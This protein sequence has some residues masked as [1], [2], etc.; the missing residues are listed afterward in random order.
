[1]SGLDIDMIE[2]TTKVSPGDTT[3]SISASTTGLTGDV[4]LLG[5]Y[6]ASI[7]TTKP[8]FTETNKTYTNLTRADGKI[9]PGD[10][11]EI[12]ITTKNSGGDVATGVI[13][14]DVLPSGMSYVAGSLQIAAGANAGAK[15]DQKAD[16][17]A[18]YD[19]LTRT[20]AFRLGTGATATA[21]GT[22]AINDTATVKFR[23]KIAAGAAGTIYNQ[24]SVTAGGQKAKAKGLA[25]DTWYSGDGTRPNVPTKFVVWCASNNDC[26]TSAPVCDTTLPVASCVCTTNA[27]CSGGL[28]CDTMGSKTCVECIPA[29]NT[30]NCTADGIGRL[31]LD[32]YQCGCI[33]NTDCN[34]RTCDGVTLR[35]PLQSSDVAVTVTRPQ[36]GTTISGGS[37]VQYQVTI[38]NKG[39]AAVNGVDLASVLPMGTSATWTCTG[40]GGATCPMASGSGAITGK[41]NLPA[42]GTLIYTVSVPIPTTYMGS[43][44][45]FR[46][47]ATVP[48]GYIDPNPGD[49]VGTDSAPFGNPFDLLLNVVTRP[50]AADGSI[51]YVMQ[52]TNK[53]PGAAPGASLS[54]A[55]PDGVTV[56]NVVAPSGWTCQTGSTQVVCTTLATIT[57]G[58]APEITITVAPPAGTTSFPVSATVVGTDGL[59]TLPDANP[60]DNTFMGTTMLGGQGPDLYLNVATAPIGSDG[61][62]TYTL[63]VGN[64]GPGDAPGAVVTYQIPTGATVSAVNPGEGWT[65]Q[66]QGSQLVCTTTTPITASGTAPPIQVTVVPPSGASGIPVGVQVVGQSASGPLTDPNPANNTYS[67]TTVLSKNGADLGLEVIPGKVGPGTAEYLLVVTNYGPASAQGA[68]VSYTIPLGATVSN[69][70]AG[71]GWTCSQTTDGRVL[72]TTTSVLPTGAVPPIKISVTTAPETTSIPLNAQVQSETAD[73][74][75][76]NNSVAGTTALMPGPNLVI[77]VTASPITPDNTITYTV[78]T[79]NLGPGTA[80]TATV[81]TTLPPGI[82]VLSVDGGSGWQCG[83]VSGQVICNATMPIPPGNAPDIKITVAVP[84]GTEQ[85]VVGANVIAKD[86][87]GQALGDEAPADNRVSVLTPVDK[88]QILGGG[89]G[90]NCDVAGP[91]QSSGLTLLSVAGLALALLYR[92]RRR[93]TVA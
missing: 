81:T 43:T 20:V 42:N 31:C 13:L 62:V 69:I 88:L 78:A 33:T 8:I 86:E 80:P 9:Y 79:Q 71:E 38:T 29:V 92:A 23:V 73:P 72:C 49:N 36:G 28:V 40:N 17:Q 11:L 30:T 84:P 12:S 1:M 83:V 93:R 18:D 51:S 16:D 5:V 89:F 53:G 55:I 47:S 39:P 44:V 4:F 91:H 66:T 41:I 60:A 54:Y 3:C 10:T 6:A 7:S 56:K 57:A 46:A 70:E 32:T 52:V 64:N 25:D 85:V 19:A 75:P 61:S 14:K 59:T 90:C 87:K 76:G 45:D 27:D 22:M 58:A 48:V 24:A 15:T 2:I 65:C 74:S 37:T 34:G 67:G 82:T 50:P 63:T 77:Q 35:C 21:G 68:S 26:S